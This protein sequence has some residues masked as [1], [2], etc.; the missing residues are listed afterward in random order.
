MLE[1]SAFVK[2][3]S[4]ELIGVEYFQVR[5]D[6][7]IYIFYDEH[8]RVIFEINSSQVVYIDYR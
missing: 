5:K 8:S 7:N 3:V 6:D 4:G 2:A 1:K